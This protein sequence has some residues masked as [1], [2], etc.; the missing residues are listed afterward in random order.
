M[1]ILDL[2]PSSQV[3]ARDPMA[4]AVEDHLRD[5][6]RD[7]YGE[8]VVEQNAKAVVLGFGGGWASGESYDI[9]LIRLASAIL[10]EPEI[11]EVFLQRIRGA[12]KG[13]RV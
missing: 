12:G 4:V 8:L 6:Q 3:L 1:E 11:A 5:M 10:Y 9:A 13:S 2:D 7:G